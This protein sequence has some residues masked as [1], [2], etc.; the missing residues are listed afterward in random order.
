MKKG[1]KNMNRKTTAVC[2]LLTL[3]ILIVL[4]ESFA[5][6]QY[7]DSCGNC[8]VVNADRKGSGSEVVKSSTNRNKTVDVTWGDVRTGDTPGQMMNPMRYTLGVIGTGLVVM[9]QFYSLRK[10]LLRKRRK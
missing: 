7:G 9:S 5:H 4:P 8:H 3:A 10:R 1:G 6:P 2:F